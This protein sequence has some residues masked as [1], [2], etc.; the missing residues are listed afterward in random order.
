MEIYGIIM[1]INPFHN[2]HL[3]FL[4]QA[5]KIAKDNLLVCIIS[6]NT[7][8]RGEFSVLS[9]DIKTKLLLENGVDI[10][11]ELPTVLAN[12]GGE[13][14]AINS[15]QILSQFNITN[16]IFGSESANI[17][18]L[19]FH[20][21]QFEL[22]DF[23]SGVNSNLDKLQSNDILGIS[24]I[25]ASKKL[26]LKL[27]FNLIKRISNNYNDTLISSEIA[28]A[29]A[30]RAS[31][32]NPQVIAD[33][34]PEDSLNNVLTINHELLFNIF[35]V[36]LQNCIDNNINIFLSENNQ[37]LYRMRQI[38]KAQK[39]N[40]I[41]QFL[42]QC[43]DRN[44]SKYKYSRI[45]INVVLMITTDHYQANDYIRILGFNTLASKYIPS[46]AFTSL[47]DNNSNI[48]QIEHRASNLFSLLTTNFQYNEFERKPLIYK[49]ER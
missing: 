47:A 16:L 39:Y 29:T 23:N 44:N 32:D 14:F 7:V 38:L 22:A 40:S 27:E 49:G 1:E 4:Q 43:K 17:D 18:N 8:Q 25:R 48:A 36:N 15:L 3:Y 34:L 10:V 24:Y 45:V 42:E 2:G 12:Q 11:C 30:I 33:T 35:K 19:I 37:L 28:S 6:T 5:R 46:K 41:E 26:G 9:K 13:Y 31:L 20:S 21:E